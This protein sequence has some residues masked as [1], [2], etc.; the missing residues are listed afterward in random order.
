MPSSILVRLAVGELGV[1]LG[2]TAVTAPYRPVLGLFW[3]KMRM[4]DALKTFWTGQAELLDIIVIK[5]LSCQYGTDFAKCNDSVDARALST[6]SM[7]IRAITGLSEPCNLRTGI[8]G[9]LRH[10]SRLST[11]SSAPERAPS[12]KQLTSG[13]SEAP[14]RLSHS[15]HNPALTPLSSIL[16][17]RRAEKLYRP[18]QS[19]WALLPWHRLHHHHLV[20]PQVQRMSGLSTLRTADRSGCHPSPNNLYGRSQMLLK[21]RPSL[22]WTPLPTKNT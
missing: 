19:G 17:S 16:S 20:R 1:I 13:Q 22:K 5:C 21:L 14:A 3:S 2:S 4:P 11:C 10:N 6:C 7:S 18:E 15:Q 8:G 12:H 9:F